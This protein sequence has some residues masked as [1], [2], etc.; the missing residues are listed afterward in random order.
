MEFSDRPGKKALPTQNFSRPDD[1]TTQ[2]YVAPTL[3]YI[4]D[5]LFYFD[6]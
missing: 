5:Y 4:L 3:N 6:W 1:Q 2:L